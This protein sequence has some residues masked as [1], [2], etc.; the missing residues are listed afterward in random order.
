M[1]L[2][3]PFRSPIPKHTG[4][5]ITQKN[6]DQESPDEADLH[7]VGI[8]GYV[9]QIQ[10]ENDGL[11][12]ALVHFGERV[13]LQ[14]L[15]NKK[16]FLN[17]E[18]TPFPYLDDLGKINKTKLEKIYSEFT[19]YVRNSKLLPSELLFSL[20]NWTKPKRS[21]FLFSLI[22]IFPMSASCSC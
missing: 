20:S 18:I 19:S 9:E 8:L 22:S 21:C 13:Y 7:R 15:V 4:L 10:P 11:E 1:L 3:L 17:A 6:P 12:S 14:K 16:P 5:F 2:W